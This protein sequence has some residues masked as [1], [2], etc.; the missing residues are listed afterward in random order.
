MQLNLT[1][2]ENLT[3]TLSEYQRA[4]D[5]NLVKKNMNLKKKKKKKEKK[6]CWSL[7]IHKKS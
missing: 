4:R 2:E 7:Q 6:R 1:W 5:S 3:G